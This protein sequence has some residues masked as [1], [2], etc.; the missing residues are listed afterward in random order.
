MQQNLFDEVGQWSIDK[1]KLLEKYLH[2]YTTILTNQQWCR[3]LHYIDAFAGAGTAIDRETQ[4]F[5]DASP[6]VA[7]NTDP[8]FTHLVFIDKDARRA[9]ELERLQDEFAY[10]DIDIY[11]GDSND[12]IVNKV[13]P[14]ISRNERAFLLI[15]PY[16]MGV[17]WQ[18]IELAARVGTFEVFVNYPLMAIFRN[19]V[20]GSPNGVSMEYLEGKPS[21]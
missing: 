10:R 21:A 4:E 19:V 13:I 7:V 8:P 14:Q 2:A 17:K 9:A 15:D 3:A 6:R 18:T 12:I 11:Q 16:G 20:R 1:L 5:L